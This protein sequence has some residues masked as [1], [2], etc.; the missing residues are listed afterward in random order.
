[1]YGLVLAINTQM[2][3]GLVMSGC[4]HKTFDMSLSIS[5]LFITIVCKE[6]VLRI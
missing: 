2:C 3:V 6:A 1:M 5:V 4:Q